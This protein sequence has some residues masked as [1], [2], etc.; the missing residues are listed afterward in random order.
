MARPS[1]DIVVPTIGRPSL[2]RLLCALDTAGGLSPGRVF[3][4]DDGGRVLRLRKTRLTLTVLDG[5]GRGPAAA[6]N[7]GW[8]ASHAE[9]VVFVDDDVVPDRDWLERLDADVTAAPTDVA[10]I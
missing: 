8:R 5:A 10:G 6:R 9:W 4:V 3:V 2:A 1:F 7:V